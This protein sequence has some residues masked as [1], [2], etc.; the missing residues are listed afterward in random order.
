MASIQDEQVYMIDREAR[1][2]LE[3]LVGYT[4][5]YPNEETDYDEGNG[6][7]GYR[8]ELAQWLYDHRRR[9]DEERARQ[10]DKKPLY[11]DNALARANREGSDYESLEKALRS[12]TRSR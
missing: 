9:Q 1:P 5:I 12:Q 11:E 7:K 3:D 10:K 8:D 2:T 4:Q 6:G